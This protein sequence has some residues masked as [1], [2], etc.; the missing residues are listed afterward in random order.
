MDNS[1]H[2]SHPTQVEHLSTRSI[3]ISISNI[4]HDPLTL[5]PTKMYND[6]LDLHIDIWTVAATGTMIDPTRDER[7][8]AG[9]CRSNKSL[10]SKRGSPPCSSH[11]WPA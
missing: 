9:T 10:L 3:A 11:M 5:P 1:P 2:T 8:Q 6:P 7:N 4:Y